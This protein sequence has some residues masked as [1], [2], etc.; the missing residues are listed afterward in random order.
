M[1]PLRQEDCV[2]LDARDE[3]RWAPLQ[4]RFAAGADG[5]LYFDAGSIGPMPRD[6]PGRV[7]EVLDAGWRVGRRRSWNETDWLEQPRRLGS[8]LA[9]ML[10]AGAADVVA[11]DSTSVNLYKLLRHALA[12]AAPRRTIV[13]ERDVFPTD[14]YVAEGLAHAGLADLRLVADAGRL[15]EALAPGDVAVVALSHV[16]YRS[17]E[18]HDMRGVCELAR[19]HGALTLWDLSHSAGAVRI[20]LRACDA[21]FAVSCGYKYLCGGPGAPSL[22][23]VHPRWHDAAWPAI[24]GWM[25]HADTFAFREGFEPASGPARHLVGSPAVLADAVF[26]AAADIWR[27][28]DP[29]ALDAR[30]RSLSDALIALLEQRC[31]DF[32]VRLQSP[33]DHERRGGHVAVRFEAASALTQ[34]L[35]EVGVIVSSRDPD[36][37]RF[38]IHPITTTHAELWRAVERMRAVLHSGAWREARFQ[39]RS[40]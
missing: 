9:P 6:V 1:Q 8:A 26:A 10:G 2:A 30:H 11:C 4:A 37:V 12:I 19:R 17:G 36:T 40:A 14:R 20:D 33:R 34:A 31:A 3:K 13:A 27:D 29:A 7:H 22:L 25:G 32:G 35:A 5:V 24:C 23:Y 18:R 16:D 21:D 15:R 28:A 39:D 38:G